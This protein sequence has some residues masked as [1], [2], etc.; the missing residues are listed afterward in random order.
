MKKIIALM[1]C[2]CLVFN[3]IEA[4]MRIKAAKQTKNK[5]SRVNYPPQWAYNSNIYEVNI[6]QYTPEGTINAFKSHLQRLQG[7]GVEILWIM[8][9]QPIGVKAR[10]GSLGSYYSISDYMAINPQMGSMEDWIDMVNEAHRL[11]MKVILDWVANHTAFDHHWTK[12]HPEYYNKDEKG[13]IKPPVDDWSDVADLN[14][15]NK[16]LREAMIRSMKFW[17]DASD[18]DGFRCDVA[19][20]V[21][22]DFWQ[23]AR[24]VL[25]GSKKGLFMLAEAEDPKL[26]NKAFDMAYGWKL[27]HTMVDIAKGEKNVN[28]IRAYL[29]EI[30][31]WPP[32]AFHMYFTDNHDENSWQKSAYERFGESLEAFGVLTF[33][34][35][36]MPLI[37]SGQEAANKKELRF[38][39]KDTIDFSS[40]SMQ[41]FYSKL[42]KL[43]RNQPALM[44]GE[45]GGEYIDLKNGSDESVFS[46]IR[47]KEDSKIL[48]VL[49]LSANNQKAK[50]KSPEIAGFTE[51]YFE[52]VSEP[53]AFKESLSLKLKPWEYKVY[54]YKK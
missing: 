20:M 10:K 51:D 2:F 16:D 31:S 1:A 53:V 14:Y 13:N 49:N 12:I 36:G 42:L 46:F 37:Y 30:E 48:F 40:L 6:R 54:L 50:I 17:V 34:L 52:K 7:M 19:Y 22:T 15:D 18:I 24:R 26:H 33:G 5:I 8:P 44:H 3:S 4:Q 45:R 32:N 23:N 38:F 27:H 28:D 39:D 41:S 43:K 25:E 35:K 9:V 11:G 21:P 47:Q 29:K